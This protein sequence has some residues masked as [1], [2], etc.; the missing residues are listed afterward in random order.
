MK[1]S[2]QKLIVLGSARIRVGRDE[3][4]KCNE[5]RRGDYPPDELI[6]SA[7]GQSVRACPVAALCC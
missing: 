4:Q 3:A 7:A 1:L 2:G 5:S 6:P